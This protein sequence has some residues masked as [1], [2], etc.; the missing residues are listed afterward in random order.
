M[1][2]A[3]TLEASPL[4][5]S[6]APIRIQGLCHH[7]RSGSLRRQVLHDVNA[8]I[9]AGEIVILTGPSGS[10]K[11]TLLTL[12]GALRSA[13]EGSLQVLGEELRGAGGRTLMSVRRQTGYIFQHHNLLES[14]TALQNVQLGLDAGSRGERRQRAR[15]MLEAVG[16]AD[17]VRQ[18]PL[19]LS[20]G[21]RQR[22]AIARALVR[23][24]RLILADEPTGSLDRDSGREV[25]TLLDDLARRE[26]VTVLLVTHDNRILD[27]ADRILHLEDGR[28]QGFGAAVL[29]S[30]RH[31]LSLLADYNRKGELARRVAAMHPEEFTAVLE[32]ATREAEHFM[33]ASELAA[34]R[35]YESMIDQL[36]E[37]FTYKIGDLLEAERASLFLLD[38]ERDELW[39]KVAESGGGPPLEIRV[40]RTRGVVG[41]VFASGEAENIPD[42]SA[43]SRFDRAVDRA[44]G[45]VTRNLLVLPLRDLEGRVFGVAEVLN[46]RGDA[47][48]SDSDLARFRGY[49][50]GMGVLLESWWRMTRERALPASEREPRAV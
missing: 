45:F 19:Q 18:L 40:E 29:S 5:R 4:R 49:M 28:L 48:F 1:S 31:M 44:S 15:A 10:G 25:V 3:Q 8:E 43:D 37:V 6:E 26:G 47:P 50:E 17:H 11:T 9:E 46:K 41:A 39:S 27:V 21:Q 20:G 23:R 30:T 12:I 32:A 14:L 16:L 22:V 13:Q 7:Y 33:R 38:P 2:T 42:A 34:D 36:L 24:P 35:A